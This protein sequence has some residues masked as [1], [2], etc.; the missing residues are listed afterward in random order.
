VG[1]KK[2]KR[3]LREYAKIKILKLKT[4]LMAHSKFED[5]VFYPRLDE[6]L[7]QAEKQIIINRAEEEIR[8]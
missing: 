6:N 7:S 5:D 1:N 4:I 3:K 2:D 8:A